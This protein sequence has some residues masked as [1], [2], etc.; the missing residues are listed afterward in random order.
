MMYGCRK[1][2]SNLI[3]FH[4]APCTSVIT[5]GFGAMLIPSWLFCNN[6][7]EE[8]GRLVGEAPFYSSN[9]P[10]R[11]QWNIIRCLL[12]FKSCS[13]AVIPIGPAAISVKC[14]LATLLL[15]MEDFLSPSMVPLLYF[16]LP[17][18]SHSIQHAPWSLTE[19]K[20]GEPLA[21]R[22]WA[23]TGDAVGQKTEWKT[24]TPLAS[25]MFVLQSSLIKKENVLVHISH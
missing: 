3:C 21:L 10:L 23:T 8:E 20:G 18:I 6:S 19:M 1:E 24:L 2:P 14:P 16:L 17:S 15:H 22:K 7:A 25:D 5:V 13:A 11:H 4:G 9:P 12:T